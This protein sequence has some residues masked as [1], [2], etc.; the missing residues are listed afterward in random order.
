MSLTMPEQT[1]NASRRIL[2][3]AL[4]V[5][6]LLA[7]AGAG[8]FYYLS[9]RMQLEGVLQSNL[10]VLTSESGGQVTEVPVRPGLHVLRGAVLIR[11]DE[12]A[13]RS[14]LV[15]EEQQLQALAMLVPPSLLRVPGVDGK[16]ESLTDRLDRQRLTEEAAERRL[17]EATGKEA[18]AAILYRRA[19]M[20]ADQGKL[21]R[22]EL[23]GA[24]AHFAS[25]RRE[26]QDARQAFEGLS[27]E[28]AATGVEIRR[29][30]DM[31]SIVGADRL[32]EG[33][34]L[35]NFEEQE[36]RVVDLRAA[37]ATAVITAPENGTVIDV[38]VRPGDMATP[39]QPSLLFRPDGRLARVR[40]LASDKEAARLR[41]GQQCQIRLDTPETVL[42]EGFV[43][44]V[45]PGLPA[46]A[47]STAGNEKSFAAVWIDVL[48]QQGDEAALSLPQKELPV[49]VTVLL[50]APLL[51]PLPYPGST[52]ALPDAPDTNGRAVV[53]PVSSEM[54]VPAAPVGGPLSVQS[55]YGEAPGQDS[56]AQVVPQGAQSAPVVKAGSPEATGRAYPAEPTAETPQ[57]PPNLPPM[58]A[59]RQ[60]TGTG[61]PDPQN[62]P[63]IVPPRMLN[64]EAHT[65]P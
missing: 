1:K 22:H 40:A 19:S 7:G 23:E 15:R 42:L 62:N 36:A 10:R 55:P 31:Q 26:V 52:V 65:R 16:D 39:M 49:R 3:F 9:G 27:L 59:P 46:S 57:G 37:L 6:L 14:A 34:R 8:V 2:W 51:N 48:P 12:A 41:A 61:Q 50:R 64:Q 63:S 25:A 20:L 5:L 33:E 29:M 45:T 21:A 44:A 4:A 53:A 11:F 13:L 43:A 17:Q 24:E 47:V 54:P 28:R 35:K 60:L 38:A 30:R 18:Q 56:S 32:S 58:R